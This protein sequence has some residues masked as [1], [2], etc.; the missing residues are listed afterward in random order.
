M[1]AFSKTR[2]A[3]VILF[4]L[5]VGVPALLH[6]LFGEGAPPPPAGISLPHIE[7]YE[8]ALE[9][10]PPL[11]ERLRPWTQRALTHVGAAGGGQAYLGKGGW[12][13]YQPDIEHT[14]GAPFSIEQPLNAILDFQ[15]QLEE[16]G[17]RLIVMPVAPKSA[18]EW[19]HFTRR[20]LEPGT[21]L[22]N[23]SYEAFIERLRGEGV[24]TLEAV[25]RA[26]LKTDTHWTPSA[27]REISEEAA[28]FIEARV[29]EARV[30]LSPKTDRYVRQTRSVKGRGDLAGMLDIDL[31][32]ER[33]EIEP[34]AAA[35]GTPWQARRGAEIL[36]LGDSFSNIYSLEEMSWGSSAGFAEQLSYA[37]GRPVDR[38][39]LN[40]GGSHTTRRE[41]ARD[42]GRLANARV[43]LWQFAA[44]ELSWGDWRL[45]PMGSFERSPE[46]PALSEAGL[47]RGV[48][49][50]L[51]RPPAP[52]STPYGDCV[53]ALRLG[54]LSLLGAGAETPAEA[55]AFVWGM[56]A[57]EWTRAASL[58]V[59]DRVE[60]RLR[61]WS[62]AEAEYG[63][64]S[65][66]EL[67]SE[68]S[69]LLDVYWG[70]SFQRF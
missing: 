40:E 30:D 55:V 66:K 31:P 34:I 61:P 28:R 45:Y 8:D 65:R 56:R 59:G 67:E 35:D 2:W 39:V 17:I 27:M 11:S 29:E 21:V 5:T 10:R 54:E 43:V 25:P 50:E 63:R 38:I 33:V 15:R 1:A 57:H 60:L 6:Q 7:A 47:A 19:T 49:L 16:R 36:L 53:I 9:E 48:V 70:E 12:L 23:P 52:G 51:T 22:R 44:R 32:A 18:V 69:W 37:L 14:S 68:E 4:C 13:F 42:S 41:L 3:I 62:E 64:Y 26:Y 24:W 20:R 58:E 46:Q